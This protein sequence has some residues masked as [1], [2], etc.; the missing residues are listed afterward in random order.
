MKVQVITVLPPASPGRDEQGG[1]RR[2]A[3]FMNALATLAPRIEIAHFVPEAAIAAPGN[4]AFGDSARRDR[5]QSDYWNHPVGVT[6]IAN[7]QRRETFRNHYI[8]GVLDAAEQP[9]VHHFAGPAQAAAVGEMLDRKPD[10]VLVNGLA[11][12]C[13]VLRS[14]RRPPRLFFDQ[15]DID[16]LVRLRWCLQP[17]LSPGKLAYLAHMPALIAAE[18]RSGALARMTFAC[19][20][21]DRRHLRRLGIGKVAVIANAVALPADPPPLPAAPTLLFL[22]SGG[23]APN[24]QAIERLVT[25]IMPLVLRQAPQARLLIAGK[26]S[27]TLPSRREASAGIEY[28]GFVPDLAGL[29]ARARVVCCPITQGGGTRVKL[30]EGAAYA[31][32]LVATRIGAEGLDFADGREILLRD[33]DA[34]FAAACVQLLR[35]SDR[36][37]RLGEAARAKALEIYDADR[38]RDT[39]V[40]LLQQS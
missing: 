1:T 34:A 39:I 11:A 3:L 30:V 31:R 4:P 24:I 17:P 23:H 32:P 9:L 21:R 19:S 28:L 10:L 38:V 33:S 2:L 13:A 5:E 37:H 8:S 36:C 7:H 18:R 6:L 27:D 29:Y 22:G 25:R 14:G 20:Q 12:M 15:M 40:R 26:G 16:H 35:D